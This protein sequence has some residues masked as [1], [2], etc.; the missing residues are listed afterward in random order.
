[1]VEMYEQDIGEL[2]CVVIDYGSDWTVEDIRECVYR[3][4]RI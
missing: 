1:M 4:H 2:G 3:L